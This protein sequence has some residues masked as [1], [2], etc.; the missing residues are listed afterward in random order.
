[1]SDQKPSLINLWIE[2]KFRE[3]IDYF[4]DKTQL[5][6]SDKLNFI[7]FRLKHGDLDI[8]TGIME[9]SKIP[10]PSET[11]LYN[12][13]VIF[14]KKKLYS[15]SLRLL[16]RLCDNI[17]AIEPIVGI[18]IAMLF[19]EVSFH[20]K[21]HNCETMIH[22]I[23]NTLPSIDFS[24]NDPFFSK[25]A[26][27]LTTFKIKRGLSVTSER[28]PYA[29]LLVSFK[30]KKYDKCLEI[31]VKL[32]RDCPRDLFLANIS[33]IY[34]QMKKYN[35]AH[36]CMD[37]ITAIEK[38]PKLYFNL[39]IAYFRDGKY[40]YAY[41]CFEF[42]S[43]YH[44]IANLFVFMADCEWM[45][46][47]HKNI[48]VIVKHEKYIKLNNAKF[49]G[50]SKR[51]QKSIFLLERASRYTEDELLT[52]LI[53]LKLA[54]LS[55]IA[56]DPINTMIYCS[57]VTNTSHLSKSTIYLINAKVSIN[58]LDAALTLGYNRFSQISIQEEKEILQIV[59]CYL[60]V[61]GGE[62]KQA[63]EIIRL[64]TMSSTQISRRNY[65]IYRCLVEM[66]LTNLTHKQMR[67][68]LVQLT[69]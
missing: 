50:H 42:A 20:L 64:V 55:T 28:S 37:Q 6:D 48:D 43:Q 61:F 36:H 49:N 30:E 44:S 21:R 3:G 62:F 65:E 8:E 16:K 9:L 4:K 57:K 10:K 2:G 52:S 68:K 18:K 17:F 39:G 58:Q 14:Y 34:I 27:K 1:M 32:A 38:H 26:D 47:N 53:H 45:M 25:L 31:L 40:E 22:F 67:S 63:D 56:V 24:P 59:L 23:E 19:C 46:T 12:V 54:Y 13:A 35:L 5:T 41:Q 66:S 33:S 51:L 60:L 15:E 11:L 29:D 69:K 7:L